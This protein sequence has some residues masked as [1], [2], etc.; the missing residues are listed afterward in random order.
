MPIIVY[1]LVVLGITTLAVAAP[2]SLVIYQ[3]FL[4]APFFDRSAHLSLAAYS[5]VFADSDFWQAFW[6][7]LS[8]CTGMVVIAVPLGALLAFL[9]VRTD[10]PGR[11]YLEPLILVPIFVSAV[12]IAFGYVVAVGPVGIFST[13][14][15]DVLGFVPWNLYSMLSLIAIAGLTHVPHVYLYSAAALR[16]L[17]TDLEEAA[18]VSGAN[19]FRVALNVSLPM[20]LPAILF[21]GVLVFFLG[22]ELFGLPLVLGD[23]QDVLV[24]STYLFKLTNKLGVPSYQLMAVVVVVIIAVT[25]PLVFMQRLLLRQ[26][27]RY[28]SVRGKGLK[29]QPLKLHGWRWIAFAAILFWLFITVAVPLF[30]ITLRSFV[31]NWG[32]GVKLSEVLTLDHY[33]ELSDYPNVVRG[34]FNT[35]GI[36]VIGGAAAVA[37]YTAIAL[38]VHRWNSG[39]TRLVDYL[40]MVP[41]AMPGLVAGLALLWVFLFVPFLSPV[42]ETMISIWLAYSIVWLAYGMRLVSGTLLQV[43]PELEEAARVSGASDLRVKRDV[44]VPLIK[45]GMLASWLLIFLIFVREYSTGIYLLGPGTEVIGS[46]LV[47]LWGTGA[48]DL[49]SALSVVNVVMIGVGLG[50]AVRLGVRLHG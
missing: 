40:V 24:L 42:K 2:L 29:T 28:V 26:A 46:L 48:I 43:G 3:S 18:R 30:G 6:T 23:P 45:Y 15:A 7:T 4:T 20:I 25:A 21:A 39:W 33:R 31:V 36:G 10:V 16:G 14:A 5:F 44:T 12:V 47:S 32:Q 27:Q 11:R 50:V 49:V 34:I 1:R 38:A 37:C 17:S 19:P 13:L 8:I 9:M 41:R 22:F 35:L